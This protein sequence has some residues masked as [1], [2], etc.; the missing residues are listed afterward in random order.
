MNQQPRFFVLTISLVG[1]ALAKVW[2]AFHLPFFWDACA[3][4]SQTAFYILDHG[5]QSWIFPPQLL[6]EPPLIPGLLAGLWALAGPSLWSAHLLFGLFAALAWIQLY[7]LLKRWLPAEHLPW[8]YLLAISDPT[9][10]AQSIQISADIALVAFALTSVNL[11]F[12]RRPLPMAFS[13]TA[14]ALTSVRGAMACAGL[15][16]ALFAWQIFQER[17]RSAR[18][19][20]LP[21]APFAAPALAFSIFLLTRHI[22]LGYAILH[23]DSPFA[24]HRQLLPLRGMARNCAV[25]VF[26]CIDF[27]RVFV[28]AAL[29]LL[30]LRYRQAAFGHF[31]QSPLA[32]LAIALFA[33][34]LPFTLPLS[35]PFGHRYFLLPLVLGIAWTGALLLKTAPRAGRAFCLLL[36]G[37]LWSG[38]LWIYPDSISQGWDASLASL[39]FANQ[40]SQALNYLTKNNIPSGQVGCAFPGNGEL[41]EEFAGVHSGKM[42]EPGAPEERYRL[43]SRL[44][45]TPDTLSTSPQWTLE[46][47]FS[48][49]RLWMKLY[50]KVNAE[51][52]SQSLAE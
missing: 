29:G 3:A 6:A 5:F 8:G 35:N 38:H 19:L 45:N 36:I 40:R 14:L 24:Q 10:L 30:L 4:S 22:A 37:A 12:A 27:G 25:L 43:V 33:I 46:Q 47:D 13:L 18:A 48:A 32:V 49:G 11:F 20:L 16:L 51:M 50:K 17:P 2:A 52:N 7:I 31:K 34:L 21:F 15:G 44:G 26:R 28:W 41:R 23:P 9:W 39:P 42:V 1:L